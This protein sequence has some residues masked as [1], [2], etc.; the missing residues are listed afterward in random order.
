MLGFGIVA[1]S[2][3]ETTEFSVEG[4]TR[5]GRTPFRHSVA[6]TLYGD[7]LS[8]RTPL[9][10]EAEEAFTSLLRKVVESGASSRCPVG[11]GPTLQRVR[12][13]SASSGSVCPIVQME[14]HTISGVRGPRTQW[15]IRP[16]FSPNGQLRE[17]C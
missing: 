7:S 13:R 4:M 9:N 17:L 8:R 3:D 1:P 5:N 6:V 14:F 10:L 2:D 15:R 12:A 16:P 11:A